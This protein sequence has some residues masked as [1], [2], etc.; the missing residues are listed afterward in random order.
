MLHHSSSSQP[1]PPKPA[2][3]TSACSRQSSPAQHLQAAASPDEYP[4]VNSIPHAATSA[5]HRRT[6]PETVRTHRRSAQ[7]P[8]SPAPPSIPHTTTAAQHR[9]QETACPSQP[10]H[11]SPSSDK[12]H[13][14]VESPENVLHPAA[15]PCLHA[16]HPRA[17]A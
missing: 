5:R 11:A 17:I 8:A 6:S 12:D 4:R 9:C 7:G 15:Q 2:H 10:P 13:A 16:S 1:C 14:A 3:A